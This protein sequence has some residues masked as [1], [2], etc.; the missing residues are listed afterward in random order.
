MVA[1]PVLEGGVNEVGA[2][3]SSAAPSSALE[4][5]MPRPGRKVEPKVEPCEVCGN[6]Y[7]KAFRVEMDGETHLFD[8]FECAIH[9]LAP[10]CS[11]CGCTVVGHGVES[12]EAMYCGAHCASQ[13]GVIGAVDR[14]DSPE[15]PAEEVS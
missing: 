2:A 15:G 9:A 12:D 3:A 13:D 5:A 8:S 6:R 10:R 7:D 14:A 1:D 11:R 4:A